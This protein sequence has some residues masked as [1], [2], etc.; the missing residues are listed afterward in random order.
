[1]HFVYE[2]YQKESWLQLNLI[3]CTD[4]LNSGINRFSNSPAIS[5]LL[6]FHDI[7]R[8]TDYPLNEITA[9]DRPILGKKYI[10]PVGVNHSPYDWCGPDLNQNGFNSDLPSRENL[11][12]FLN[13]E[14]LADLQNGKAY[15]LLDQSHEGYQTDWLWDW[16]HNSCAQ[17]NINPKQIIYI[18]GNTECNI[19]YNKWTAERGIT[20]K[21]LPIPYV[22]FENVMYDRSC[23]TVLPTFNSH[24]E[25][26][27]A[28]LLKIKTYNALQKRP[29]S[30]RAWLFNSLHK[31]N[32]VDA[33]INSMN[34]VGPNGSHMQGVSIPTDE[35]EAFKDLLPI[36]PPENPNGY[37]I[38]NYSSFDSGDYLSQFNEQ[39]M[40][41][42]WVT[43]VSEASFADSDF[44]CFI[45]EKTFK[46][47]ACFHPFII[48]GNRH[49]LAHLRELGYKTF[50]PWIDET[51][52]DLTTW[53]RLNA[54]VQ[55]IERINNIPLDEKLNWYKGMEEILVHNYETFK[56]NNTTSIPP[57][58]VTLINYVD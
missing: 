33:G 17:F 53:D 41:D 4:V 20:D 10:I 34:Y 38:D 6:R 46:P 39:T 22:H 42:T 49:S 21:L 19:Q 23:H 27:T 1:M 32:L 16:F 11:F 28:N 55:E 58:I 26:K 54:V 52:D 3:K 5:A 12:R 24:I 45:S 7:S 36:M 37:T 29:R 56:R 57:G 15:L 48:F 30:H 35:Y 50:S 9:S 43:V 8:H 47:I 13:E 51:Y 25:Y 40:L 18:T 31:S 2:Q 44:T 14:Y